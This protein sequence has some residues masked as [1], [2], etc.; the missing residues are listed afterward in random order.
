MQSNSVSLRIDPIRWKVHGLLRLIAI[1]P[2]SCFQDS[3][4]DAAD[5][6]N[7]PEI[8]VGAVLAYQTAQSPFTAASNRFDLQERMLPLEGF[9][10]IVRVRRAP[11]RVEDHAA[12]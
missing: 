6:Y 4:L 7:V 1:E 11:R 5:R 3:R 8:P 10:D 12:F 2:A 9:D